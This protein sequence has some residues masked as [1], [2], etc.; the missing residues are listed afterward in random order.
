MKRL[1]AVLLLASFSL[2]LSACNTVEGVGK[3]V[4]KLGEKVEDSAKK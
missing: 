3:D 2:A 1:I 4:Q